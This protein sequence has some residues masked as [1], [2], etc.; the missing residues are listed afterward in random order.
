MT[1]YPV[2]RYRDARAAI[3]WLDRAFAFAAKEVHEGDDGTIVHAELADEDGGIVMIGSEVEGANDD[4][5]RAG[6]GW[7]YVAVGDADALHE[8][9]VGAGARIVRE[10]ADTDYG[11]RDFAAADLEGNLW[12]FGT[13][14]P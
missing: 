2:L 4:G 6:R 8:R 7:L 10:L 9:A 5:E 11:S 1:T 13:Y 3:E 14:R 12:S